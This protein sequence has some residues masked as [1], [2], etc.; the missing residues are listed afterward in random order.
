MISHLLGQTMGI[1]LFFLPGVLLSYIIYPKTEIIRR[2]TYSIVLAAPISVLVGIL[3]NAL[4]ALTAINMIMALVFLNVSFLLIILNSNQR[5]GTQANTDIFYLSFFSIIGTVWRLAFLNSIKNLESPYTYAGK[6]TSTIPNLGFYTGMVVDHA[7]FIGMHIF[8]RISDFLFIEGFLDFFGIFL[9]T[10]LFLGLIYLILCEYRSRQ[11]AFMGVALMALGPV[12]L[13]YTTTSYFGHAFSYLALLSLFLLFKSKDNNY[14]IIPLLLS[15]AMI[16]TYFTSSLVNL[17]ASIGFIIALF[18]KQLIKNRNFRKTFGIFKN[19]KMGY[20]LLISIISISFVFGSFAYDEFGVK[21]SSNSNLVTKH[22]I[23]HPLVMYE[24]PTFLGLS[25]IRWQMLFFF[26]CGSTFIFYSIRTAL[27][28]KRPSKN[29][30]DLLLCLIP[31]SIVSFMFFYANYPT[32]AFNYFAFFGLL[33]LKIPKKYMRLF[34]VL[35]FAFLLVTGFFVTRDKRVFFENSDKEIE[36]ALWISKSLHGKVF[37][38]QPFVNKL[39]L[40]GYYNVT[41]ANDD[42]VIVHNLFYQSNLR[43]P[44]GCRGY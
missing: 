26:L 22:I 32:R 1:L 44:Q 30:L 27:N 2:V 37:S 31:V 41:G 19:R 8:N 33:V 21:T 34:F 5:C 6:F 43:L 38:D 4:G 7:R 10:F 14:V 15:L 3:L 40:N 20:F 36:G 39:V 11:L 42:D 29:D 28:K 18:V 16:F 24:D 12:E 23:T 35:S 9:I 25:A 13:F 17:F